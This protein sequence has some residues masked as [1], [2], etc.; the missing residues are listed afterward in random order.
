LY[1]SCVGLTPCI[2]PLTANGSVSIDVNAGSTVNGTVVQQWTT[3]GGLPQMFN[4]VADGSSWRI[5]MNANNAKCVDLAGSGSSLG[6]GTQLVIADC[7]SG[8]T[9]Q[10]WTITPEWTDEKNR[11]TATAHGPSGCLTDRHPGSSPLVFVFAVPSK[12]GQT[13]SG[14]S[15]RTS[16][17][18]KLAERRFSLVGRCL[19]RT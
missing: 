4:L 3:N 1:L 5:A 19:S 15:S 14:P 13:V 16:I 11:R 9:S 10:N 12:A 8:D 6:D 2:A 7:R 17:R 18:A